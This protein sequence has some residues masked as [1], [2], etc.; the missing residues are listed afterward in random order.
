MQKLA[1]HQQSPLTGRQPELHRLWDLF[2]TS[3]T[4][5]TQVVFVSGE[6]GIGK[7]RLL[8]EM[9]IRAEEAGALVLGG[10]ASEAEGMP[11]YL[12]FLEALGATSERR[13]PSNCVTRLDQWQRSW[14]RFC[15][16]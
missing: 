10:G 1:A 5:H 8:Q 9:A 12:P 7:S 11:P 14:P 16:N 3:T 15:P 2:E 13:L 4:G 6:P